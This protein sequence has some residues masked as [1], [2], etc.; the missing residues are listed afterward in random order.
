MAL[1]RPKDS[2]NRLKTVEPIS[3]TLYKQVIDCSKMCISVLAH[4]TWHVLI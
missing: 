1:T 2:A 3:L 4:M